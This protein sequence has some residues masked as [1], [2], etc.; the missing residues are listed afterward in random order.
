MEQKLIATIKYYKQEITVELP[1]NYSTFINHLSD[2]LQISEEMI[3]NFIIYYINSSD[4]KK[5]LIDNSVNYIFFL[6]SVKNN[7]TDKIYIELTNN[8][9]N[10]EEINNNNKL[11][12]KEDKENLNNIQKEDKKDDCDLLNNPYKESFCDDKKINENEKEIIKKNSDN[13]LNNIDDDNESLEFS[14]LDE[15]KVSKDNNCIDN[16]KKIKINKNIDDINENNINNINNNGNINKNVNS[17][18]G[19]NKLV[20]NQIRGAPISVNFN[21]E[22]N[23]CKNNKIIG[24]IFYC[25]NCSIFFCSN[26]EKKISLNHPHSYY[27]IRNKEQFKEICIMHNNKINKPN[28]SYA[29]NYNRN[30]NH[31]NSINKN[32]I[33]D[34]ISEGSKIVGNTFNSFITF[35]NLNNNQNNSNS[36]NNNNYRINNRN[37]YNNQNFQRNNYI[38]NQNNNTNNN[39]INSLLEK[40]KSQYNLEQFDDDEIKKSLIISKG[41]I[42]KAVALLL[43]NQLN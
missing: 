36:I 7:K 37:N 2:M 40:A 13:I 30:I 15:K 1:M 19:Q 27:Q 33:A 11:I 25:N 4:N 35:F 41:N 9:E 12:I 6:D 8:I 14:F 22:C 5:K 21:I 39:N 32:P 24:I 42:D 20:D 43:S 26:C 10:N 29:P 28:E 31:N 18:Y 23:F 17:Y 3:K 38:N 34:I 16:K